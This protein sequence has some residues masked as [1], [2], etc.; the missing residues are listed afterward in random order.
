MR[1]ECN[2]PKH[3]E[4]VSIGHIDD[5]KTWIYCHFCG[6]VAFKLKHEWYAWVL[7]EPLV[8]PY[9]KS[10]KMSLLCPVGLPSM[11]IWPKVWIPDVLKDL[12]LL[13]LYTSMLEWEGLLPLPLL[14]FKRQIMNK[15]WVA[16]YWP[17]LPHPQAIL[18]LCLSLRLGLYFLSNTSS[19]LPPRTLWQAGHFPYGESEEL[20][21]FSTGNC[22]VQPL[23]LAYKTSTMS[24]SL[25]EMT[26]CLPWRLQP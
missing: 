23:H 7:W 26:A 2:K 3:V 12:N 14:I 22:P 18:Y 24:L 11:I 16:G 6:K 10:E 5:A 21:W 17:R 9:S 20:L 19:L 15:V 25:L 8:K 4:S 1:L 13:I